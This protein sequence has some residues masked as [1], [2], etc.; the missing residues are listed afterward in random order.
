MPTEL[1]TDPAAELHRQAA[2]SRQRGDLAEAERLCRESVRFHEQSP[3][4]TAQELANDLNTLA[5]IREERGDAAESLALAERAATL[6][7]PPD[8][9][10]DALEAART[11]LTAWVRIGN[12]NRHLA[13]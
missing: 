6:L 5:A 2:D 9:A 8:S 4:G 13:R 3:N 7:E 11:L 1:L 10:Y 12:L